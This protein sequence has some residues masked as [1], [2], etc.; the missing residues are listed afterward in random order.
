MS[1][2]NLL[3]TDVFNYLLYFSPNYD[4]FS[5]LIANPTSLAD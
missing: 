5:S 3:C 2:G 1:S 4:D